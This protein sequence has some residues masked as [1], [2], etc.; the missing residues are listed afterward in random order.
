MRWSHWAGGITGCVLAGW[1]AVAF[2]ADEPSLDAGLADQPLETS[3]VAAA[4]HQLDDGGKERVPW[5]LHQLE[6]LLMLSGFRA[7]AVDEALE[8]H[9]A[10]ELLAQVELSAKSKDHRALATALRAQVLER[11][12]WEGAS[13]APKVVPGTQAA[14]TLQAMTGERGWMRLAAKAGEE[15]TLKVVGCATAEARVFDAAGRRLTGVVRLDD[16]TPQAVGVPEGSDAEVVRVDGD[17]TCSDWKLAVASRPAPRA[18]PRGTT[19]DAPVSIEADATYRVLPERG[20]TLWASFA[21][22][23]GSIYEIS[24]SDLIGNTDTRLSVTLPGAQQALVDDDGGGGLSSLVRF[25]TLLGGDVR[26]AVDLLRANRDTGYR[27]QVRKVFRYD[28]APAATLG[29]VGVVLPASAWNGFVVPATLTGGVGRVQF[30]AVRGNVYRIQS[31]LDVTF[32]G[33]Q[34]S[35]GFRM[36]AAEAPR[37]WTVRPYHVFLA[38]ENGATEL[39]LRAPEGAG[40]GPWFLQVIIEPDLEPVPRVTTLASS[41]KQPLSIVPTTV[42]TWDGG[43]L[44]ELAPGAVVW[45]RFPTKEQ[46]SY[47]VSAEAADPAAR[48]SLALFD[49]KNPVEPLV[50]DPRTGALVSARPGTSGVSTYL[51]RVTNEGDQ[52][53]RVRLAVHADVA[54]DGF[55]LGDLVKISRHRPVGG[56]TNWSEQMAPFIGRNGRIASMAGQDGTGS[57]VVRLDVD[58]GSWVWRT[59]DLTLAQRAAD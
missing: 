23:A 42:E 25:D 12:G 15:I 2:A 20:E 48:L 1:M 58:E 45:A 22:E 31:D 53:A 43:V 10:A 47:R 29:E 36:L 46:T 26:I 52:P 59:R 30:N 32:V 18:L 56:D 19:H 4:L 27:L 6:S 13:A 17:E 51:A 38:T 16:F 24:T 39:V 55:R 41:A 54:Y 33:P 57:W 7:R 50:A 11:L 8:T 3:L 28:V 44:G 9:G 14:P 34:S 49:A 5:A 37:P 35:P 21:A 40:D